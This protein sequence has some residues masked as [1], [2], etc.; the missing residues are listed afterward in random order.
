MLKSFLIFVL[1]MATNSDDKWKVVRN[2]LSPT[3]TTGKIRNMSVLMT[4]A[5]NDWME[6]VKEKMDNNEP[7]ITKRYKIMSMY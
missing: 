1:L 7:F 3:L 5:I 2:F 6:A 4:E